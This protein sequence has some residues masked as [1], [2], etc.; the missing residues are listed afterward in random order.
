MSTLNWVRLNFGPW[1]K[2]HT[3]SNVLH[4]WLTKDIADRF[5]VALVSS[6]PVI[7][8][9]ME[10][11]PASFAMDLPE[12]VFMID[13]LELR[14][15]GP[16]ISTL[17]RLGR[18]PMRTFENGTPYYKM[19]GY[20]ECLVLTPQQYGKLLLD[21]IKEVAAIKDRLDSEGILE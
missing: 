10:R 9:V 19:H 15:R 12:S 7:K 14:I 6:T 1:V 16:H 5:A 3:V 8:M 20:E 21:M 4:H 2:P 17:D 18:E 13:G 11:S